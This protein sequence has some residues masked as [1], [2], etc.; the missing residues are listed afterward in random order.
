MFVAVNFSCSLVQSLHS[1]S[2]I[3]ALNNGCGIGPYSRFEYCLANISKQ[4]FWQMN[5]H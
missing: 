4:D 1:M 3:I 5:L 2:L